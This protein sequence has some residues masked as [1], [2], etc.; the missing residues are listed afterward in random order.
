MLFFVIWHNP[1]Y[2]EYNEDIHLS[3]CVKITL[4]YEYL[5]PEQ[6]HQATSSVH[7]HLQQVSIA[8]KT[9]HQVLSLLDEFLI[10]LMQLHHEA[11]FLAEL[12]EE[13]QQSL[14]E[15]REFFHQ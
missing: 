9:F 12:G 2:F 13:T 11:I 4:E 10:I 15:E 6:F 1:R 5:P 14:L 8:Y 3:F 7:C